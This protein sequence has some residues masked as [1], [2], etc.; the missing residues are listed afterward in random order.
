MPISADKPQRWKADIAASVDQFN[1]WFLKFA[2][3]AYR[4]TRVETTRSVEAALKLTKDL[5]GLSTDL[6][7]QNPG[8]LPTLRMSTCP[9]LA[10]DRL[11]GLA[12]ATKSLVGALEDSRLPT[13]MPSTLLDEY[14]E[15]IVNVIRQML[16]TEL[17][18][19]LQNSTCPTK[20]ERYRAST[21]IAD[22]LCGAVSDPIIRNAQEKRQLACI[23]A[24][25]KKK[26]YKQKAHA[27]SLP[28]SNMEPGTFAFRMNVVVGDTLK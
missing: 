21:I 20:R 16:D 17:F 11:T 13:K 1:T 3:K 5:T 8:I 12:Y 4:D 25:L 7:K 28:L 6:L 9:P 22:R 19:W 15:R 10:R 24:Y 26:G 18:P 27:P 14:L 2:P 23:A